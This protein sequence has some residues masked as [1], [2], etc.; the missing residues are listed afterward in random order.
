MVK[1]AIK[2]NLGDLGNKSFL[3][4]FYKND[5]FDCKTPFL[6]ESKLRITNIKLKIA[7]KLKKAYFYDNF[8]AFGG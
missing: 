8:Q 6:A 7:I 5:L 3:N 4:F 1:N 2:M